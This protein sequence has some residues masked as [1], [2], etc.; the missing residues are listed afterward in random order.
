MGEISVPK[1]VQLLGAIYSKSR[2]VRNLFDEMQIGFPASYLCPAPFS[3][4][5]NLLHS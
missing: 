4:L 2:E 5:L 1:E 3:F